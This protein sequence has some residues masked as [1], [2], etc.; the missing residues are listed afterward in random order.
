MLHQSLESDDNNLLQD[1]GYV[2]PYKMARDGVYE[3][4]T[5]YPNTVGRLEREMVRRMMPL[6]MQVDYLLRAHAALTICWPE[7]DEPLMAMVDSRQAMVQ[8]WMERV[9]R[10]RVLR[11]RMEGM[12]VD[13]Q[14]RSIDVKGKGGKIG[15]PKVKMGF[16]LLR[17]QG[18][19][20][21]ALH[22]MEQNL[23]RGGYIGMAE[24]YPLSKV[25]G[26]R[27]VNDKELRRVQWTGKLT[28]LHEL[29]RYLIDDVRLITCPG[30]VDNRWELTADCFLFKNDRLIKV[31]SLSSSSGISVEDEGRL[32]KCVP[33]MGM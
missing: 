29:V 15:L 33:R 25:L 24:G 18:D 2:S 6:P 30:G 32:H 7:L 3:G 26:Y 23:C 16:V 21:D 13:S 11:E 10:S 17:K 22:D 28:E 8:K 5:F 12:K 19:V 4:A 14:L 27:A 1:Y 9:D 20:V 31:R